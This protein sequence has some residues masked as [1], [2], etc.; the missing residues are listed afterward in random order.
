MGIL[1]F[2]E[3]LG[4]QKMVRNEMNR[5]N[6]RDENESKLDRNYIQE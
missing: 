1:F 2:L 4:N 3:M 5:Y 6:R